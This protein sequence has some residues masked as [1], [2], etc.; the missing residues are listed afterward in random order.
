MEIED[1]A[2]NTRVALIHVDKCKPN[3]CNQECKRQCPVERTGKQCVDAK[4][5]Y[6]TAT[7]VEDLCIGCGICVKKCPFNAIEI[8]NIPTNLNKNVI[9]RYGPNSFKLIRFPS[10]QKGEIHGIIGMNGLGKSTILNILSGK[11]KI[12]FGKFNVEP[13]TREQISLYFRG[14]S[15]QDYFKKERTFVMKPQFVDKIPKII[16][17]KNNKSTTENICGMTVYQYLQKSKSENIEDVIN[18][19]DLEKIKNRDIGFLSGGELQRFACAYV[20]LSKNADVYMF[21]EFTSYLDIKQRLRIANIILELK[22]DNNYVILVEHDLSILDY[23]ADKVNILYGE[24][25]C[26]GVVS[27]THVVNNGINVYL[28]G[29]IPSDNMRFRTE[30][31]IFD[32]KIIMDNDNINK[33][34]N[35][36]KMSKC[37]EDFKLHINSGQYSTSAINVLLGENGVGKT[38]F[39]KV[40]AGLVRPDFIDNENSDYDTFLAKYG[41]SSV[42]YKPQE[43]SIFL[44]DI[45]KTGK[46]NS[47]GDMFEH[48]RGDSIFNSQILKPLNIDKYFERHPKDLSGGELQKIMIAFCLAKDTNI[49]LLDEPSA[50]LDSESR[51]TVSKVLKRFFINNKKIAFIVEHDLLM[52]TYLADKIIL[53]DGNPGIDTYAS[54][55]MNLS[56]GMNAFLKNVNVTLRNDTQNNR[57]RINKKGSAKDTEQKNKNTYYIA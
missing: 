56:D 17:Q 22:T 11:T 15:M 9:H 26:Y 43:L 6:K 55:P 31:F 19:F 40:L 38:T 47:V 14:S 37:Y 27:Q 20:F 46:Y 18:K 42:S 30:P 44:D 53:F 41:L 8:V 28:D 36:P 35:Y 57:P 51:I 5:T 21:D 48:K 10:P 33:T 13:P 50:F 1:I 3:K 32:K 12:N 2:N 29:Y 16:K 54:S 49:Y 25:N 7:I 39:I 45:L 34:Y 4:S 24:P 52:I 23:L